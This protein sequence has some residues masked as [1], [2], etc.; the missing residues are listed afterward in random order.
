MKNTQQQTQR[1]Y[2]ESLTFIC[3]NLFKIHILNV[4][5]IKGDAKII[6]LNGMLSINEIK[7][8]NFNLKQMFFIFRDIFFS[9]LQRILN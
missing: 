9:N 1:K 3:L 6:K 4:F 2:Y 5:T 8:S 7:H